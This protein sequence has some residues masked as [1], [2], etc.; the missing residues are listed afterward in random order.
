[1]DLRW[2]VVD[3]DMVLQKYVYIRTDTVEGPDGLDLVPVY[4]W[5]TVPTV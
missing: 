4:E 3:G 1:M 2:T 5:Q